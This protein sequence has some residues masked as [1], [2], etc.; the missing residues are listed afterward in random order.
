M[1]RLMITLTA[2]LIIAGFFGVVHPAAAQGNSV[3][4][5]VQP[6]DNLYRIS[7]K[8]GVSMDAIAKANG[9]VNPNFVY[10]GQKLIIPGVKA[11]VSTEEATTV[12][13]TAISPTAVP[14]DSGV[15][16]TEQATTA[17]Q[18]VVPTVAPT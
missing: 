15:V 16:S 13:P 10:V 11:V 14:T 1:K 17:A 5:I 4:Y 3:T 2:L 6:G 18:T 12:A 9:I 8:F 7:L